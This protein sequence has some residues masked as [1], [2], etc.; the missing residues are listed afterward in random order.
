MLTLSVLI[1]V[2]V[3][4]EINYEEHLQD[5]PDITVGAFSNPPLSLGY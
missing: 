5:T 4:A 2:T 1:G 3:C